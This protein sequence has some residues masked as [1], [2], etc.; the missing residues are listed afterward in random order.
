MP[1]TMAF[2]WFLESRRYNDQSALTTPAF[3]RAFSFATV[4]EGAECE[5]F[6]WQ[7]FLTQSLTRL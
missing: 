4:S 3:F 5:R 7:F 6:L 2:Q 1:G